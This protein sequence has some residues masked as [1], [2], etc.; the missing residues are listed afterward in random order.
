MS[1]RTQPMSMSQQSMLLPLQN[2]WLLTALQRN[3]LLLLL[4]GV[5]SGLLLLGGGPGPGRM[6]EEGSCS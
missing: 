2:P 3:A 5:V 4:L 1:L 6:G